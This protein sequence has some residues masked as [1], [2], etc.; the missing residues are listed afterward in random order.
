MRSSLVRLRGVSLII[1][2]TDFAI[3]PL[4]PGIAIFLYN[5]SMRCNNKILV[6][7]QLFQEEAVV[8]ARD[9]G[10]VSFS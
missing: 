6:Y 3:G 8:K 5:S 7:I 9:S 10:I 1:S 2:C 4:F